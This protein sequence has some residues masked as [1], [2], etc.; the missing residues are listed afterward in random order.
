M[1]LLICVPDLVFCTN[2]DGEPVA[3][4]DEYLNK[5]LEVLK[6]VSGYEE[7]IW[8][9]II[10]GGRNSFI[11]NTD[12]L[13]GTVHMKKRQLLKLGYSVSVVCIYLPCISLID[14]YYLILF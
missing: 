5:P 9:A 6:D 7:I 8:N 2:K 11:R 3:I 14:I 13:R 12:L 10:V 1:N 4:P